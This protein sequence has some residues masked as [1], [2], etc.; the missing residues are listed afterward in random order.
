[1]ETLVDNSPNEY[2]NWP[3]EIWKGQ[4]VASINQRFGMLYKDHLSNRE[5]GEL[6]LNVWR[7]KTALVDKNT[8]EILAH[9]IDFST[10]ND[11]YIGDIHSI[12]FWLYSDGCIGGKKQSKRFGEFIKQ[13]RGAKK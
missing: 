6:F 3:S 4:T 9:Q 2:P 1:M 11:G 7:W 13:L 12:K 8:G 10:G 5:E